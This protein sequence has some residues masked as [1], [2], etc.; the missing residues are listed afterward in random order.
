MA[1]IIAQITR[2][3]RERIDNKKYEVEACKSMYQ[4]RPFDRCF[5]KLVCCTVLKITWNQFQ[6]CQLCFF[7]A[8][9]QQIYGCQSRKSG[10]WRS[11]KILQFRCWKT[12]T[13]TS[14]RN[15]IKEIFM[16]VWILKKLETLIEILISKIL[17]SFFFFCC[18]VFISEFLFIAT[19][20]AFVPSLMLYICLTWPNNL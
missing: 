16:G 3:N 13:I 2:A 8:E 1:A 6:C 5:D 20:L 7:F 14:R 11:W 19:S 12:E 10:K 18:R 15:C 4:I 9:T 17:K